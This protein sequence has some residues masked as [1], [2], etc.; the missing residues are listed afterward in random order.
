MICRL[1]GR[2]ADVSDDAVVLDRDGIGYEV[3][4]PASAVGELQ[5]LRGSEVALFTIQ[6]F[7]GNP[8][9]ANLVPRLVGFLTESERAF[10]N[11]FTKVK[12]ISNRRALRVMSV[13]VHQL[14]AAIEHGDVRLLTTLPEI[15]K[16]TAAQ[17]ITELQGHTQP[18]L[19][20]SAAP[21][22]MEELTSAQRVALEILVQWGD[23]RVDAQ[24]WVAA[25]VAAEPTL[26][27]PDA[28]VRA[29]YR[30]RDSRA[31]GGVPA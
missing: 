9:G 5:R 17:I 12:G 4:V 22:P 28:I 30:A 26:T 29:A 16:K 24:R 18:F 27:E 8:A 6:Y 25:A 11:L 31:A 10:F 20:P 3:M 2:L 14:A 21:R 1:T 13:P 7:E 23:R 19:E 15:G